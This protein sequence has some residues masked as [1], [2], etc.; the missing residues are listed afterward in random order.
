MRWSK[1]I[2]VQLQSGLFVP[3]H[4]VELAGSVGLGLPGTSPPEQL[5]AFFFLR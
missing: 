1:S 2:G 5:E 4:V 3:C